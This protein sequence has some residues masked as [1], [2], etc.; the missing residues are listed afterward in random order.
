MPFGQSERCERFIS[1]SPFAD[2]LYL[3]IVIPPLSLYSSDVQTRSSHHRKLASFKNRR[4]GLADSK[5]SCYSKSS[6]RLSVPSCVIVRA[7]T[8]AAASA[9]TARGCSLREL[10]LEESF[11]R[12]LSEQKEAWCS[13]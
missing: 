3:F 4:P 5:V 9:C 6:H 10:L 13:H 2:Y 1:H 8:N 12:S 11:V 7:R